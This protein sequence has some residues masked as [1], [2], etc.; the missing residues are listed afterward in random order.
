MQTLK[1]G[2]INLDLLPPQWG[3]V[4]CGRRKQP[5]QKRWQQ[6]PLTKAQISTEISQGRCRAVGVLCGEQSGGLLFV[7]HDGPSCA[8]LVRRLSGESVE[9][10]LPST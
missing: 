3:L 9:N 1:A 4:A 8:E 6:H 5:Y 7:D 2:A 10:A